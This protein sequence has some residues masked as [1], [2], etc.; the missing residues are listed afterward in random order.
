MRFHEKLDAAMAASGC[1]NAALA[2]ALSVHPSLV[3]RLREGK[4]VPAERS[5]LLGKLG[6]ALLN[7]ALNAAAPQALAAL[8]GTTALDSIKL[9][10]KLTL[11][12]SAEDSQLRRLRARKDA[13]GSSERASREGVLPHFGARLDMLMAALDVS[14]ATLARGLSVDPSLVSRY[15]SSI[16]IPT[17]RSSVIV[18]ISEWF[19]GRA[20]ESGKAEELSA[21]L[22]LEGGAGGLG[23][24]GLVSALFEWLRS[25][26]GRDCPGGLEHFFSVFCSLPKSLFSPVPLEEIVSLYGAASPQNGLFEG[27][28][29]MRRAVAQFLTLAARQTEPCALGLY[30]D[31]DMG[32]MVSDGEFNR[33]W[34]SLMF[35]TLSRG[36]RIRIIHNV[37]RSLR[38]MLAAIENWLPLYMTGQIEPWY[39]HRT[40]GNRFSHSLFVIEG[41]A[42]LASCGVAGPL[43]GVPHFLSAD[44]GAAEL[45]KRQFQAL[46]SCS[47]PLVRIFMPSQAESCEGSAAE[48]RNAPGRLRTFGGAPMPFTMPEDLLERMLQRHGCSGEERQSALKYHGELAGAFKRTLDSGGVEEFVSLDWGGPSDRLQAS[49]PHSVLKTPLL[50]SPEELDLHRRA[51]REL[52]ERDGRYHFRELKKTRLSGMR[53]SLKGCAAALVERRQTP[54]AFFCS[55][56]L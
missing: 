6:Q 2:R 51:A 3:S 17:L 31:Q 24:S 33:I 15:R 18:P 54:K 48:F 10:E 46:L 19:V 35:H 20:L 36:H 55:S 42:L 56:T 53:V 38:E 12:F 4:R 9:A 11:W 16:R 40:L 30:S 34:Q 47:S 1:S 8:C 25:E 32:W 41:K 5:L 50:Y 14:N 27:I 23:R 45:G 52:A 44:S 21:L 13:G 26:G 49:I 29:G 7:A 28:E 22:D 39:C 37:D 43:D